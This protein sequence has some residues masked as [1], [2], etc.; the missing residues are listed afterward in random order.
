MAGP[1]ASPSGGDRLA[2]VIF[3]ARALLEERV[4]EIN[5]LNVFPVADGDTGTNMVLTVRAIEIAARGLT[6][7]PAADRGEAIARAALLGARGNSGMILS[8][9]VRGAAD[10]LADEPLLDGHA[11][12]RALRGASDTAY[13][14]V[15]DPVEGTMLTLMRALAEGAEA[16]GG[17]DLGGVMGAAI[18]AGRRSLVATQDML[19]QL[20]EAGVVD[21]GGLGVLL[22]VEALASG[23]SG[24]AVGPAIPVTAPGPV[25]ADHEPST[26]RYCTSFVLDGT[27]IALDE[28]EDRLAL[29][30]D[31]LLVMGDRRQAKVH[32]HT[33]EPAR[34]IRLAEAVG[35]VSGISVDDMHRQEEARAA[36][37]ARRS[38]TEPA[39]SLAALDPA[40][41][42]DAGRTALITDSAADLPL[43]ARGA[44]VMVA[45][46]PVS[47]GTESFRDG[48]DLD[49][50]AFYARLTTGGELPTTAAPS[51]GELAEIYGRALE[52]FET[53][54]VLHMKIGRAS[55]RERV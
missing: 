23:L 51:L 2:G 26:F 5:D 28:L 39:D 8:Q 25:K 29:L 4:R 54:V 42:L 15:R 45:P 19:P 3:A 34:A 22:I 55:C 17:G 9:M 16:S 52:R 10:A 46:V 37:I 47:F 1:G 35:I 44:N 11:L 32:V 41:Q 33:D 24:Q 18:E 31:S 13:R 36:R 30:G 40:T 6:G 50:E 43:D 7:T 14:A 12:T 48:V 20:R 53:A 27:A 49:A 21:A 38:R